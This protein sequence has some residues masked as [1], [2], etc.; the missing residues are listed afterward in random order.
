[1]KKLAKRFLSISIMV[2]LCLS[3]P[4]ALGVNEFVKA[5]TYYIL[6]LNSA[7]SG[8]IS[9]GNTLNVMSPIGH[10]INPVASS[11][12][13]WNYSIE[14]GTDT[15]IYIGTPVVV[16]LKT[17]ENCVGWT[18]LVDSST[19][20]TSFPVN[21]A[22]TETA[23]WQAQSY[24][25]YSNL[26]VSST[27][28]N[29]PA[30]FSSYWTVT[31]TTLSKYIF[32]TNNTG[33]WVNGTA[34]AFSATPSWANATI[35]LTATIGVKVGYEFY[36]NDSVGNWV[37]TGKHVITTTGYYI[38]ASNDVHSNLSPSGLVAVDAGSNQA[39]TFSAKTGYS[40]QNVIIDGSTH[41]ALTSPYTF[42]NVQGNGSISVST[43]NI[44]YY[45]NASS[46]AGCVIIPSGIIQVPYGTWVNF[47]C[48]AYPGAEIYNLAV[49]GVNQ[50]PLNS[51]NLEPAENTTL[52]LTSE[53]ISTAT[54]GQVIE[55]TSA[56]TNS[57]VTPIET[58]T[59]ADINN[60]YFVVG[61]ITLTILIAGVMF[62]HSKPSKRKSREWT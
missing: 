6:T 31:E 28:A 7:Y 54:G 40:I 51:Y 26:A 49:N 16:N 45:V 13:Q 19:D 44:I 15:N 22:M 33:S 60:F 42:T 59:Q 20:S 9:G 11:S 61:V 41:T 24:I 21:N 14:A 25:P 39:F 53:L 56:P 5:Q 17:E 50:G 55:S 4:T 35:T 46:D 36:V 48:R 52:Y 23:Q 30:V 8:P 58:Q 29:N 27:L 38:T 34:T 2:L 32:S 10:L 18:G 12:T 62:T 43:S 57:T 37:N 47:T 3:L 1:M